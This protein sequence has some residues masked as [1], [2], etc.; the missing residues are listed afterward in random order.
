MKSVKVV[1]EC[2]SVTFLQ[3]RGTCVSCTTRYGVAT[4]PPGV[5]R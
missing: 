5:V 4:P 3:G 2:S 1:S